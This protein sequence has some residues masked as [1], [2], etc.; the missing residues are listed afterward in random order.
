MSS[1]RR[2]LVSYEISDPKRLRRV[3]KAMKAYGWPMHYSVFISDL[4][5]IELIDLKMELGEAIHH[6]EDTIAF[7]DLGLPSERGRE[8]FE[9]LGHAPPLPESGPVIV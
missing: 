9:F 5:S 6:G 4:D 8:C 2:Y 7:V 3:H 1:R